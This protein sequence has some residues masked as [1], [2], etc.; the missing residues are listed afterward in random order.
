MLTY[1]LNL[2]VKIKKLFGGS[3]FTSRDFYIINPA[4]YTE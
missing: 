4:T 2:L 1:I 3:R